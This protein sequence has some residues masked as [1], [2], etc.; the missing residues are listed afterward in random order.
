MIFIKQARK[1]KN[2]TVYAPGK[3]DIS[4]VGYFE[5]ADYAIYKLCSNYDG[6]VRGGVRKTWRVV[7]K[8][9]SLDQAKALLERR[10]A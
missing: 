2:G 4:P 10:V 3:A 8:G 6:K 1:A 7:A 5:R 9:L